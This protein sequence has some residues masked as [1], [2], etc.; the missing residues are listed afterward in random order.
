MTD[1]ISQLVESDTTS[2]SLEKSVSFEIIPAVT[3]GGD[4]V[5]DQDVDEIR[6]K[7]RLWVMSKNSLQLEEPRECM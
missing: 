7:D 4:Q 5:A 6:I 1:R 3:Q 2:P